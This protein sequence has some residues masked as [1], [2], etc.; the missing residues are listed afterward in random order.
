MHHRHSVELYINASPLVAVNVEL[1]NM[2]LINIFTF[3]LFDP[4]VQDWDREPRVRRRLRNVLSA[5]EHQALLS[6]IIELTAPCDRPEDLSSYRGTPKNF[7]CPRCPKRFSAR[8]SVVQHMRYDCNRLPRFACPY[9]DMR[10]KWPFSLYKH[11]RKVHAGAKVFCND[12]LRNQTV[13]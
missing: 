6:S 2:L 1:A 10:S 11:I 4:G 7:Q 5:A 3:T 9:C 12:L 13:E 8:S